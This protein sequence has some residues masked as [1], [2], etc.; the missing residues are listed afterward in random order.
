MK[1][2]L[3]FILAVFFVSALLA[4]GYLLYQKVINQDQAQKRIEE[5]KNQ[6]KQMSLSSIAFADDSNIPD[7]YTCKGEN[8]SPPLTISHAPSNAKSLAIIMDDPDAAKEPSGNGQT[9]DHWVV[10]NISPAIA[11]ITENS[12]L[13]G[14]NLGNN[15]FGRTKYGGPCP[16]TMEHTYVF[17]LYAL[18]KK[19]DLKDGA[20]RTEVEQA[21]SGHIISQAQ[22]TG[23]YAK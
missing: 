4:S 18:D 20:S 11:K 17:K 16:P 8:I 19:L 12:S 22:L 3:L 9:F 15:S 7:K 23:R 2:T 10:F 21:I 13:S 5:N 6:N 14:S 1:R